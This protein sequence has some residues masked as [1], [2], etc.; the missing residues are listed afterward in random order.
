MVNKQNPGVLVA[1]FG[2]EY[3]SHTAEPVYRHIHELRSRNLYPEVKAGFYKEEPFL[4]DAPARMTGERIVVLP[5]CVSRGLFADETIPEEIESEWKIQ[6][7]GSVREVMFADPPGTHDR[8]TDILLSSARSVTGEQ[9]FGT[10]WALGLVGHGTLRNPHHAEAVR[11]HAERIR[12]RNL[13]EEVQPLFLDQEPYVA[14]TMDCI[15]SDRIVIVPYFMAR[16][17]HAGSDIP[18]ALGMIESRSDEV[19]AHAVSGDRD[20]WYGKAI[21]EEGNLGDIL[22]E[23]I[24][25]AKDA[26]PDLIKEEKTQ[27]VID[28]DPVSDKRREEAFSKYLDIESERLWGEVIIDRMGDSEE[29]PSYRLYHREDKQDPEGCQTI[30]RVEELQE[31][32]RYTATGDYRPLKSTPDLP[33]GWIFRTTSLSTLLTAIDHLYPAGVQRWFQATRG[34]LP[35]IH[36]RENAERQSGFYGVVSQLTTED[37]EDLIRNHCTEDHC[38]RKRTWNM[39]EEASIETESG[40]GPLICRKPCS[41]IVSSGRKKVISKEQTEDD[42][43]SH[44]HSHGSSRSHSHDHDH[45]DA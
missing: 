39:S 12:N 18:M 1:A 7:H 38:L 31:M 44:D 35:V 36:F 4:A 23:R 37:V 3:D 17:F 21:A 40:E 5:F 11:Y 6:S 16:G 41:I 45:T 27:N 13:F 9:Q 29:N 2:S 30:E 33:G 42:E 34:Q 8:V 14:D 32:A 22:V 28:L 25:Q 10:G 15:S 24:S 43:H 26:N 19:P 20:I